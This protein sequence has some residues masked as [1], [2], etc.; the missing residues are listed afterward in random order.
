MPPAARSKSAD[1]S[2]TVPGLLTRAARL[3][4]QLDAA[5]RDGIV[6]APETV[7]AIGKAEAR[8]NR[9]MRVALWVI[10]VLLAVLTWAIIRY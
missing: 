6:L 7:A 3:A 8:R 1:S 5:T 9:G 2:A 10:V 4:D